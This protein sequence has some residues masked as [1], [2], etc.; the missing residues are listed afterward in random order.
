MPP[1]DKLEKKVKELYDYVCRLEED[2]YD[3]E[4][5]IRRQD[6]EVYHD[7]FTRHGALRPASYL[8]RPLVS[9]SVSLA[10]TSLHHF[11]TITPFRLALV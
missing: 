1:S 9:K 4:V 3:W 10:T 8:P 11:R 7:P 6:Y 5:K 2:K